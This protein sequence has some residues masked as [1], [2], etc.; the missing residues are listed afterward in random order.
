M[1][2]NGNV[3]FNTTEETPSITLRDLRFAQIEEYENISLFPLIV[4]TYVLYIYIY[5]YVCL[6]Y[7]VRN[8]GFIVHLYSI[9]Y[10]PFISKRP[11]LRKQAF[12]RIKLHNN[13]TSVEP[14]NKAC[15]LHV[16]QHTYTYTCMH[17]IHAN[18]SKLTP[19]KQ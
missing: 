1:N 16:T 5:T 10:C 19:V 9:V 15:K 14:A 11:H 18:R 17:A 4:Y 6:C 12:T 13:G 3:A 7:T 8:T 2:T